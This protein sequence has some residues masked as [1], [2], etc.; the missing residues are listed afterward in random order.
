MGLWGAAQAIAFGLGGLLGAVLVDLSSS[1][2]GRPDA[3]YAAVFAIEAVLFVLAAWLAVRI[4]TTAA[5]QN[6][7]LSPLA[8][9]PLM[10]MES[11]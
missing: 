5:D 2:L 3:A 9:E 11:R 8:A 1:M 10:E 7:V 6:R 4:G